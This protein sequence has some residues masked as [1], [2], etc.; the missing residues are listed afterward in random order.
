MVYRQ[1]GPRTIRNQALRTFRNSDLGHYGNVQRVPTLWH[2]CRSALGHFRTILKL[3][4]KHI[5]YPKTYVTT[6]DCQTITINLTQAAC[7][8]LQ[9][10]TAA[11]LNHW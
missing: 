1:F 9:L 5:A 3:K 8:E 7:I 11:N 2:W 4:T 10:V 6:H